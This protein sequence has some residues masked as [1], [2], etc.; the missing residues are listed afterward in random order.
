MLREYEKIANPDAQEHA[1]ED[2]D[3][4]F[5]TSTAT[6]GIDSTMVESQKLST[7]LPINIQIAFM[8]MGYCVLSHIKAGTFNPTTQNYYEAMIKQNGFPKFED[9]LYSSTGAAI[10]P[11]LLIRSTAVGEPE[12]ADIKVQQSYLMA[13]VSVSWAL[14]HMSSNDQAEPNSFTL[15]SS[16][17]NL[18]RF[19]ME[20][21]TLASRMSGTLG[22]KSSDI[23]KGLTFKLDM[24]FL[25]NQGYLQIL[26]CDCTYMEVSVDQT[27]SEFFTFLNFQTI[28]AGSITSSVASSISSLF[29]RKTEEKERQ[30]KRMNALTEFYKAVTNTAPKKPGARYMYA[31]LRELDANSADT[32][33]KTTHAET[34][35]GMALAL[36]QD[37]LLS[38]RLGFEK[39]IRLQD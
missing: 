25:R 21:G 26:P 1:T 22:R 12:P 9:L 32:D 13:V 33:E 16:T 17:E 31:D 34:F 7:K 28:G 6:A 39:V 14:E 11:S 18:N 19:F 37:H 3:T 2:F 15:V 38:Y 4:N 10:D 8:Q 20:Y 35:W 24:R 30:D 36:F 29:T 27:L 5:F 23:S